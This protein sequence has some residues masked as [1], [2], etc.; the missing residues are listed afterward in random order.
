[1]KKRL[2]M[3]LSMILSFILLAS[4][5]SANHTLSVSANDEV[6]IYFLTSD[7][8]LIN[9]EFTPRLLSGCSY[10]PYYITSAFSNYFGSY[11]DIVDDGA[12]A[13]YS[14]E[15]GIWFDTATSYS[16]SKVDIRA[17]NG[18]A[19]SYTQYGGCLGFTRLYFKT[20]AN[21]NHTMYDNMANL[22]NNQDYDLTEVYINYVAINYN[23]MNSEMQEK[24]QK[25]VTHELGHVLGLG[26][27]GGTQHIMYQCNTPCAPNAPD[28]DELLAV[29]N[30]YSYRDPIDQY[31]P[32]NN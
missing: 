16:A 20:D 15:Y 13:W 24:L 9:G 1:M 11:S 22:P 19:S 2:K 17:F 5:V 8:G 29:Q 27:Y 3:L 6:Y 25:T 31:P 10:I 28:E 21:G 18:N 12:D 14:G 26:H 23:N 32:Q 30:L 7:R 4:F